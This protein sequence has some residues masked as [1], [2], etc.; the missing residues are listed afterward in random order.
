MS[1]KQ[2]KEVV[3]KT[4]EAFLKHDVETAL[5]NMSDDISWLV[6]GA[7]RLSGIKQGKEEI[8][9]LRSHIPQIFTELQAEIRGIYADGDTVV[10]EL[11]ARGRL[12]SGRAYENEGCLV[13]ELE[14]GKIRRIREYTDT[15]RATQVDEA[16]A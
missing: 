12:R 15:Q 6:P 5:G 2:N 13:H 14:G 4:W 8:R 3:R 1:A 10:I 9:L 11:A 7:M 16:V